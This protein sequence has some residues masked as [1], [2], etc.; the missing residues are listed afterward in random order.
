MG[1]EAK[2]KHRA[3][4]LGYLVEKLGNRLL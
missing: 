2:S 1:A 3:A 4:T